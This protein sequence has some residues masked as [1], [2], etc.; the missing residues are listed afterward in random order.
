[1]ECST[2]QS[3]RQTVLE[4]VEDG[5]CVSVVEAGVVDDDAADGARPAAA[6]IRNENTG[7]GSYQLRVWSP[8]R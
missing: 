5:G 6:I 1:V 7:V 4:L 8:R 2:A 3:G